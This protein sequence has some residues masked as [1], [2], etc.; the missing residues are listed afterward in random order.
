[1][2]LVA[3]FTSQYDASD[4]AQFTSQYVDEAATTTLITEFDSG[5]VSQS[6]SSITGPDTSNPVFVIEHRTATDVS[7]SGWRYITFAGD[8]LGGKSCEVVLNR[9]KMREKS[10][11][12]DAGWMMAY[13]TDLADDTS[14]VYADGRSLV[15]G[16][17]GT[18]EF[19][20]NGPLPSGV[21]YFSTHPL[22]QNS[23]AAA[24]ASELLA[25][26]SSVA[27]PTGSADSFA[28]SSTAGV[29][30]VTPAENDERG[31]PVGE[32]D[33]FAIKLEFGGSTT[34]GK[35]KRKL[36]NL[37]G[38]HAAGEHFSWLPF[39]SFVR[40]LLDGTSAE[41]SRIRSNFDV[42]LYFNATPNGIEAGMAR[43]NPS[44]SKDPNRDFIDK[45]LQEIAALTAAGEADT[46]GAIDAFIS[47]HTFAVYQSLYVAATE[48]TKTAG[49]QA[50]L[51]NLATV[52]GESVINP[53]GSLGVYDI[54][55]GKNILGAKASVAAELGM[56]A[57]TD[58]AAARK[59]GVDWLETLS[60]TDEQG[61][62]ASTEVAGDASHQAQSATHS[63]TGLREVTGSANH[64]V[65]SSTH[66][67][68]G[69]REITGAATH[70]AQP[71]THSA[72]GTVGEGITGTAD[73]QAQ[74]ATH[75]ANGL[76][77]V[78]GT[79]SHQSQP[80]TH[81]ASGTA[82]ST[83]SGTAAHQASPA[84]HTATGLRVI[85]GGASHQAEPA[86]HTASG[87]LGD[88]VT[89]TASHQAQPSTHNAIGLRVITGSGT[90][91][92]DR[93]TH[94]AVGLRLITGSATHQ[95]QSATHEASPRPALDGPLKNRKATDI[96]TTYRAVV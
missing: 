70:Q 83:T 11:G 55:W 32:N 74:S 64:Q 75:S 82:G 24:F 28:G 1:M 43:W 40:E 46:G 62:L 93:V 27:S 77:I 95:A 84:T 23:Y 5:N 87:T 90:N 26:Y 56:R 7:P 63:A 68:T 19:V 78:G 39:E 41:A 73:H 8:Q 30:N 22:K 54:S 4:R 37:A 34:D 61:Y 47:W 69:L 3:Q 59:V 92:A 18:I 48:D 33:Q 42:Y 13:T 2:A 60:L 52:S 15:G 31:S 91:V 66:S 14:W 38:I 58:A 6:L 25:S 88:A 96:S 17:T 12:L 35:P 80:A 50:M 76:R 10:T 29:Y 86:T 49:T 79:A 85:T 71:A 65:Q 51:D 94:T 53:T 72:S 20:F 36:L 21:V 16:S 45:D 44:R 89:G 57:T 67:A 9:D 81:T